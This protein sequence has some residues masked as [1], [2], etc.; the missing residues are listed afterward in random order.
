MTSIGREIGVP[1]ERFTGNRQ[2]LLGA[3]LAVLGVASAVL[4]LI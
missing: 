1:L 4:Q 3:T 2:L